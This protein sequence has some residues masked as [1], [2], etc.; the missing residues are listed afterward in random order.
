MGIYIKPEDRLRIIE[1]LKSQKTAANPTG[2]GGEK[3]GASSVTP[4]IRENDVNFNAV[5][6]KP[7]TSANIFFDEIKV[8]DFCQRASYIGVYTDLFTGTGSQ[9]VFTLSFNGKNNIRVLVDNVEQVYNTDYRVSS[10]GST[11]GFVTAP[12]NGAKIEVLNLNTVSTLKINE[13]LY[14][15]TSRAYAEVLGSSLVGSNNYIYLNEN[16]ITINVAGPSATT[17]DFNVNDYVYQTDSNTVYKFSQYAGVSSPEVTFF[18]KIKRWEV[19]SATNGVLV[20]DPISG[21]LTTTLND[22]T[23]N[24]I[25]NHSTGNVKAALRFDANNKFS[26]NEEVLRA[27]TGASILK[28][29]NY[30]GLSSIVPVAN[31]ASNLKSIFITTNNL[32]RDGLQTL[33]GNAITIVSGTNMGFKANVVSTVANATFNIIETVLDADLPEVCTSNSVYSIGNHV[34]NDVGAMY[35][36]FHIPSFSSLRWTVGERVFTITDTAKYN[37]NNYGMRAITKY[38]A[39]GQVDTSENSRNNVLREMTPSSKR[40][41]EKNTNNTQK[42]NDR[43]FM[44]Q[45]FFT[46]RG[47]TIVNGE[48]KTAF[49]IYVTSIDLFFRNKP[50]NAEELLPFTVAISKVENGIPANDIIASK[51]LDAALIKVSTAPD[52]ANNDSLTKFT[53]KDPVY[54]LPETEYAIKL[55]TESSDYTLWTAVLGEEYTDPRG[56]TRRISE[57]PYSG[58]FFKSQNASNWNPILNQDLMFQVN[59]ASFESSN[60]YF[61]NLVPTKSELDKKGPEYIA[62]TV[63]DAIKISSSGEQKKSPTNIIYEVK[64]VLAD[65]TTTE[66]IKVDNNNIY[67]FAQDTD[68]STNSS[69]RRRA[70][71]KGNTES[72]NVRV[73]M[74]TTDSTIS[75]I[76]NY[77][78]IS[79]ITL[80][81]IIN[82]ASIANNFVTITNSGNHQNA[83]N[84]AI[85][86]S[87]PDVGT[88]TTTANVL[89]GM[90]SGGKLL[91]I[92]ITNP[93]S[94]YYTSPTITIQEPGATVNATAVISGE[95]ESIGGN[96]LSKYQTKIVTLEEGFD[97]GDLVV[98]LDAIKPIG[99]DVVVYFKVLSGQDFDNFND[100]KWQIMTKVRDNVSPDMLKK[101]SLEYRHSLTR[102]S[103]VY[104]EG[105]KTYPIGGTFKQFAIKIGLTASDP[106][107]VPSV[108]SLRVIAV[109]GG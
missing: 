106:T 5:N 30:T 35:G 13:G 64:T 1:R 104:T 85:T 43:K 82:N 98:R 12:S 77:E 8:N 11:I 51:T 90:L 7:G 92:N 62:N 88:N 39:L 68:I 29:S 44:A 100:K 75:P 59:R 10:T 25:F 89:P 109:P 97:A 34:V 47:S 108:E 76:L 102:G 19:V 26:V 42:I 94:G 74:S 63:Y 46:P 69:S 31:T 70:I 103:I 49:G 4:F 72:I 14:G 50:T 96:I 16:F 38:V 87:D 36:I 105:D 54:L 48:V 15:K 18:G 40:A 73:T 2:V 24:A 41:P 84:I 53:F 83:H 21:S 80:Q 45:T 61:F 3:N 58:N 60:T 91:A 6:L 20:I 101:V 22:S 55:I 93:G 27:E 78:Q 17:T 57:E 107:I 56:N 33:V 65:G 79:A 37:D 81:N 28:V 32:S 95:T 99:T 23:K 52:T 66:Y 86:F 67:N 71:F 9:T